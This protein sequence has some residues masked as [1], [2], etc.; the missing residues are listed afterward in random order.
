MLHTGT[1]LA[2]I[3]YF[4]RGWK[5][6]FFSSPGATQ[7]YAKTLALATILT[8]IIGFGLKKAVEHFF[9]HGGKK[10]EREIEALF[11]NLPLVGA[12]LA[13]AGAL[14]IY[15]G[16]RRAKTANQRDPGADARPI[17]TRQSLL[18]GAIQGL[19]LPFRGFSRSGAT[20]SVGLL[21]G[22]PRR[23]SEEFSFALAV[24]ITPVA[25]GWELYRLHEHNPQAFTTGGAAVQMLLPGLL[26]LVF[27]FIGGL[28]ALQWLSRWLEKG[29][30]HYFGYYCLVAAAA[31]LALHYGLGY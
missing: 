10:S 29:R 18:I 2:V 8:G 22:A 28:L 27:S 15:A 16:W 6:T 17:D 30:W 21:A 12:A 20:I 5:Q 19:C 3:L 26:G 31:V 24:I 13:C 4:W 1:M 7:A 11:G 14:I 23:L 9:L 25:L